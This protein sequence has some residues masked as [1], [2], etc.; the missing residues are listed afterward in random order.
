VPEFLDRNAH[1]SGG[2]NKEKRTLGG[3]E[4][5]ALERVDEDEL[6]DAAVNA[7]HRMF[8]CGTL[9]LDTCKRIT[10]RAKSRREGEVLCFTASSHSECA[11]QKRP[12]STP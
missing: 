7:G 2:S 12:Y 4:R 5:G 9:N 1:A 3:G 8:G 6:K 10:R 11:F